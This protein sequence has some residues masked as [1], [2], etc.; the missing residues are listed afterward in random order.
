MKKTNT[1][2]Y[3]KDV[4]KASYATLNMASPFKN[5]SVAFNW[6]NTEYP[7]Q[8]T[9]EHWEIL[10]VM[11]GTALHRINGE[12]QLINRGDAF[13]IRP[14]DKHSIHSTGNFKEPYQHLN[15]I[16][17]SDFAHKIIDLYDDYDDILNI[18]N[19]IRFS[20]DETDLLYLHE[21]AL[22]TQNLG[23]T[24]Y[25]DHTKLIISY[26][27][28]KYF[29]QKKL[30]NSEYP[31]WLNSFIVYISSPSSFGKTVHELAANTSYSYS[32]LSRIFKDYTGET[33]V[34]YVNAKKMIYAKRLLRST[35]LS[36]L[37]ISSQ[38]GY[39][40]LS[41]FNHL[42]KSTF[43]ITPSEYRKQNL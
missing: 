23:R 22:L 33:I 39:T 27:I 43:G 25:E 13:L 26:L 6:L 3:I 14:N 5:V 30:F 31:D 20:L 37:Q 34:N 28:I 21:R 36:T 7:I 11:S 32:R 12:E 42:F 18:K 2:N 29:E 35:D 40:S 1:P 17:G 24:E 8:H 9:H 4:G 38:I 19:H 10:V 16:I 15:F 41:S